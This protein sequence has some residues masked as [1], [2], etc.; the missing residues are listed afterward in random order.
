M[1]RPTTRT[2]LVV[3][4]LGLALA[5]PI[6]AQIQSQTVTFPRGASSTTINARIQGSVTRD[7]IVR[8]GAGQTMSVSMR[9]TNA[10]TYFNILP[11]GSDEALF[12]GST[13]GNNYTGRLPR[14]GAYTVRVYLMRNAAR[15]NEVTNYRLTIGVVGQQGAGQ[16]PG[17][18]GVRPVSISDIK[19]MN[20]IAAIDA[21]A[22]RGFRD[23]DSFSSGN[24]LYGIYFNP[25]TRQCVQ[26]A[27]A[28][29]R[30]VDASDIRT[31][32]KCR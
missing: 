18:G 10:S 22:G 15:R 16:R 29:N 21:M 2:R 12:I 14:T 6:L 3:F 30:V 4:G 11:E 17:A 24:S 25:R 27:N 1:N 26:L 9:A 32:P 7:Y 23:V 28:N 5:T 13:A 31:H 19:G 20:S 8:A